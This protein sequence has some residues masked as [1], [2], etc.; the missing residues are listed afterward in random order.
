[1]PSVVNL[2]K[3]VE[4]QAYFAISPFQGSVDTTS[5]ALPANRRPA[6]SA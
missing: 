5:L 6:F 3:I 2:K 1:M 4:I